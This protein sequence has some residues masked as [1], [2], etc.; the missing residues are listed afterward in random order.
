MLAALF[1][2]ACHE[3][4]E[5]TVIAGDPVLCSSSPTP[6]SQIQGDGWR[7]PLEGSRQ[8]AAGVVTAVANGEG[9]YLEENRAVAS[10][11]SRALF[12][13]TP[14][15]AVH[16]EPGQYWVVTGT[17]QEIGGSRDTLT[18]LADPVAFAVCSE[19]QPLPRSDA[20]L[21]LSNVQREALEGMRLAFDQDVFVSD[22][23]LHHRGVVSVS[24]GE[25]LRSATE[26]GAPGEAAARANRA[27]R[28]RTLAIRLPETPGSP[29]PVGSRAGSVVGVLGHD[30]RNPLLLAENIADPQPREIPQPFPPA[31]EGDIRVVSANLLNFFNGDG[32]GGGFPAERGARSLA[33][34]EEQK[35]RTG[36]VMAQLQPDLLAVQ[37]LE[38]DGYGPRSAASTLLQ[39]LENSTQGNYAVI[40]APGGDYLGGDVISVGLFYLEA[41]LEPVGPPHTLTAEPFL[42]RSRQPL[43]QVFRDRASGETFL[44]AVNH[45]KSKG[46]CPDDGP[47]RNLRDGQGCWNAVRGESVDEL[48]PWLGQIAV[49]SGTDK[50]LVVGDMNAYRN[51]EPIER[52]RAG[53]YAELV[54]RL[55]GLPQYSVRFYGQAGTLD[56][57][58]ASPALVPLASRAAIW[59]INADWPPRMALP[60]PW[61]RMSDHDPVI[62]DLDFLNRR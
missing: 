4:P 31:D 26:D 44:V 27:N 18:T 23:Y 5:S 45:L 59:P 48:L 55:S 53:G 13:A 42:E 40:E 15:L 19:Q 46:S 43:A 57:A 62:I 52:F 16:A 41:T 9:M 14:E 61:L 7:S 12:V 22:V 54:E 50:V 30:G 17:V 8:T 28:E 20:K 51:E 32:M 34:F 33:D 6:I 21:P 38:N 35:A 25:D 37:E 24:V 56:Y 1:L 39:V 47:N 3:E 29:L 58:F 10:G 36:A 2:S 60:R 11:A 49:E